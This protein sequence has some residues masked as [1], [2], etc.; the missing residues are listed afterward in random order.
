MPKLGIKHLLGPDVFS[1]A[2]TKAPRVELYLQV[3][4]AESYLN[5]AMQNGAKH[6]L[7]VEMRGWGDRVGYCL[8][9]DNHVV[10]F[11]EASE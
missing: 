10:A 9:P 8:D 3:D 6:L 2:E 1:G 7:D 11:A 5:L 4:D